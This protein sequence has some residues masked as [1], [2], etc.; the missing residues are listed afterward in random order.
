VTDS[1]QTKAS[2]SPVLRATFE[3]AAEVCANLSEQQFLD[4]ET[5]SGALL[6]ALAATLPL[7]ANAEAESQSGATAPILEWRRYTKARA[8]NRD[9]EASNGADFALILVDSSKTCRIAVFQAKRSKPREE[10]ELQRGFNIRHLITLPDGE[11]CTQME[12]LVRS[13]RAIVKDESGSEASEDEYWQSFTWVHYLVYNDGA[14]V[15]IPLRSLKDH[16]A[17]EQSP[18]PY[19]TEHYVRV[20]TPGAKYLDTVLKSGVREKTK[21]WFTL[22]S[23]NAAKALPGLAGILPIFLAGSTPSLNHLLD[24]SKNVELVR[25]S[26]K[27]KGVKPLPDDVPHVQA[28]VAKSS[29]RKHRR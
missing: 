26:S 9:S 19:P 23:E 24:R 21:L 12:A 1:L 28:S 11:Q 18:K 10:F 15:C 7:K 25:E 2:W 27:I 13:S 14:A 22:S 8:S 5:L 20:N 4:E 6:G 29:N 3:H 17:A 16:Y